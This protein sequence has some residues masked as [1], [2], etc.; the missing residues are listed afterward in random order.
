MTWIDI[1]IVL[2][3]VIMML[4]GFVKGLVREACELAGVILAV[5]YAYKT[6]HYWGDELI[7][8][9]GLPEVVAYPVAFG[10]IAIV[11]SVLAGLLGLVLAKILRY[12]PISMFDHIGGIGLGFAKGFI[13]VCLLLVLFS[14]MPFEGIGMTMNQSPLAQQFLAIVPRLYDGLDAILPSEFPRW[15]RDAVQTEQE[16]PRVLPI[17]SDTPIV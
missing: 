14:A 1:L 5:L 15:H 11:I 8:R 12:T 13:C 16:W 4:K 9:F 17:K 2:I 10:C 3:L 6:Y 7:Y